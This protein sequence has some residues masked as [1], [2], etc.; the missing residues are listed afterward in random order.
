MT[1][2]IVSLPF[3]QGIFLYL[4]IEPDFY[5]ARS[6]DPTVQ[7]VVCARDVRTLAQPEYVVQEIPENINCYNSK[8]IE[9]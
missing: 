1:Y 9:N 4:D 6:S 5:N 7:N 8:N 3:K 2:P